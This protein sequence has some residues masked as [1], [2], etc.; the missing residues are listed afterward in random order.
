[1]TTIPFSRRA[2]LFSALA[3]GC[4]ASLGA[5]AQAWPTKPIKVIAPSTAGGAPDVYARA[6]ADLMSR[7]LGQPMVVENAPAV[8]GMVAAQQMQ[9]AQP[10]GYTLLVST[11]GMMTITPNANP[12]ARYQP[13][14]F[15]PICQGVD[16]GLVLAGSPTLGPKDFKALQQWLKA[17]K[18]PPSYSSYSPGSPAHF[19]GY[20]LSEAS[21]VP[22]THVPYRS[23]P[24]QIIDMVGGIAPLGFTQIATAS[25]Q[26]KAGKLVAFATTGPQRAPE[27]P[28]VP[29]VRELGLP[30]LETTV[31]FGL[32]GPA[33]LP[34]PVA[35]RLTHAHRKVLA[36][37]EFRNR[38]ATSG[39]VPSA[40]ICG[41]AFLKKMN[42]ESARWARIVKATGFVAD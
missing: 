34:A 35:K 22:M 16:A 32:T 23:G 30:Q 18:A 7:E 19:L 20:Q 10:D 28:D 8:G 5:Q 26:I 13:A 9:R 41:D 2:V 29:T 6:L 37:P 36:S 21:N 39:L 33:G 40:D 38:M 3:L 31:W 25:P 4:L 15:T 27:L 24:Q 17:E 12:K 42:D 14:D 1:M 11:A